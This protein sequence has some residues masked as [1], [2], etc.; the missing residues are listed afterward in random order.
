MDDSSLLEPLGLLG[1]FLCIL[2]AIFLI[3]VPS[4]KALANRM[5]A[6]FLLL[7][8][9][10]IS[11]WFMGGWWLAHPLLNEL[12]IVVVFLQ[13]P[14]FLGFVWFGCFEDEKLER[15]HLMH[16]VPAVAVAGALTAAGEADLPWLVIA[17]HLQ[18]YLYFA[19]AIWI[20]IRFRRILRDRLS[21]GRSGTLE[22][23]TAMVSVSFFAH[24]IVVGRAVITGLT[25]PDWTMGLQ[26]T[27][28]VIVLAVMLWIAS[29]ALHGNA[30]YQQRN[31]QA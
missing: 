8:A 11:G 9:V 22:W 30:V 31:Y 6:G 15:R 13:M 10:D 27:S 26:V 12:R 1:T 21:N 23:L 18:Y 4:R 14:M 16:L 17:L 20:L 2:L 29:R 25:G 7:T 28:A 5:L 3:A 19:A 24:A